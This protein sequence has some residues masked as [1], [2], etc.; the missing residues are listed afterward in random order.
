MLVSK[1]LRATAL[2][3]ALCSAASAAEKYQFSIVIKSGDL[4][5]GKAV[6]LIQPV[7]LNNS[8]LL[9][10]RGSDLV[11]PQLPCYTY[12]PTGCTVGIFSAMVPPGAQAPTS[13]A[14]LAGIGSV[15]GGKTLLQVGRVEVNDAGMVVFGAEWDGPYPSSGVFTPSQVLASSGSVLSG[16]TLIGIARDSAS[17]NALGMVAFTANYLEGAAERWGV[18]SPT[19]LLAAPGQTID[20]VTLTFTRFPVF[21]DKGQ[22]FFGGEFSDGGVVKSAIFT[23]TE[24]LV[25]DDPNAKPPIIVGPFDVDDGGDVVFVS[26]ASPSSIIEVARRGHKYRLDVVS[27]GGRPLDGYREGWFGAS[28]LINRSGTIVFSMWL[29]PG[30]TTGG[31]A[32]FV[33]SRRLIGTGDTVTGKTIRQVGLEALNDAGRIVFSAQFTDG[34]WGI[35]MADLRH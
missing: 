14:L 22:L 13:T 17:V 18:F 16:K 20:G 23:P 2:L 33:N 8:G 32:L 10:F 7:A 5:A 26:Q 12:P 30:G 27:G 31:N 3:A 19:Q 11:N 21:T 29:S 4:V 6:N 35:V 24:L 15:I 9:V 34:S 25:S 1:G 28:P